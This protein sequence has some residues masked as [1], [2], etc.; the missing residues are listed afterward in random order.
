MYEQTAVRVLVC[1]FALVMWFASCL[2]RLTVNDGQGLQG[3]W[4]LRLE[5]RVGPR[6]MDDLLLLE[7][8]VPMSARRRVLPVLVMGD[9]RA[10]A[11][12]NAV[13]VFEDEVR[14]AHSD[15]LVPGLDMR[16]C[17][18]RALLPRPAA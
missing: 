10:T 8:E 13:C 15:V 12:L 4:R 2:P 18:Q 11:E 7:M 17:D 16:D 9:P 14:H 5:A 1:A 3:R 6:V